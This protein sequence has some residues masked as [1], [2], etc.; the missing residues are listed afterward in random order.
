MSDR[1]RKAFRALLVCRD[2]SGRS[3]QRLCMT[4]YTTNN[5]DR[6]TYEA[7]V[8]TRVTRIENS[9]NSVTPG[10]NTKTVIKQ[11]ES[12]G[13]GSCLRKAAA[14]A[15]AKNNLTSDSILACSSY[16]KQN[17][18]QTRAHFLNDINEGRTETYKDGKETHV[19]IVNNTVPKN[20]SISEISN[21]QNHRKTNRR[22]HHHHH[23]HHHHS[24]NASSIHQD[25]NTHSD[26]CN[27]HKCV[28]NNHSTCADKMITC[29]K[30]HKKELIKPSVG[31]Y[32]LNSSCSLTKNSATKNCRN[33]S[34]KSNNFKTL[35]KVNKTLSAPSGLSTFSPSKHHAGYKLSKEMKFK[36]LSP[37][38]KIESFSKEENDEDGE[39]HQILVKLNGRY[40][41]SLCQIYD[42]HTNYAC[43]DIAI[44]DTK[45]TSV[46]NANSNKDVTI[47]VDGNSDKNYNQMDDSS[48][49]DRES[50][51]ISSSASS[52]VLTF[53]SINNQEK[54]PPKQP[55]QI[56]AGLNKKHLNNYITEVSF[57]TAL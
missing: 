25:K 3:E 46:T 22:H 39:E 40:D 2:G 42:A 57:S 4:G 53:D 20:S 51:G 17:T 16:S 45:V 38:L 13:S 41:R 26:K 36:V 18:K 12:L 31:V 56:K 9:Y 21:H 7:N 8:N 55:L 1:F 34:A 49:K 10:I 5:I 24:Q 11:H 30:L 23:H 44:T 43:T 29:S 14:E 50:S 35:T 48:K 15:A 37:N 6:S 27:K 54:K 19:E 32:R 52:P 47:L 33:C 28:R